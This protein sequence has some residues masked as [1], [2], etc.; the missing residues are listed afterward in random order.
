MVRPIFRRQIMSLCPSFLAQ[1]DSRRHLAGH[2]ARSPAS[3]ELHTVATPAME[4]VSGKEK[5][6]HRGSI[7]QRGVAYIS[8]ID[9]RSAIYIS[10]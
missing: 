10:I 6:F 4:Y 1:L 7:F 9:R 5:I 8:Q 2:L 3:L